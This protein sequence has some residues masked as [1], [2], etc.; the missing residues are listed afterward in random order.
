MTSDRTRG[1]LVFQTPDGRWALRVGP[2]A[3]VVGA[4]L[5][6]GGVMSPLA[7]LG[8]ATFVVG[9]AAIAVG[10]RRRRRLFRCYRCGVEYERRFVLYE[11]MESI[12]ARVDDFTSG[13]L[14][15][16][17]WVIGKALARKHRRLG[18]VYTDYHL[19]F[20]GHAADG[21]FLIR[22]DSG[23]F[24]RRREGVEYLIEAAT[25]AIARRM[26]ARLD[27]TGEVAWLRDLVLCSD[28]L[29]FGQTGR[30]IPYADLKATL[31]N[32]G[33]TLELRGPD[34]FGTTIAASE[35]NFYPGYSLLIENLGAR[36]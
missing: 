18:S 30:R 11:E 33:Q 14:A 16:T 36:P 17:Q 9:L 23:D 12:Q 35:R 21:H 8:V 31:D 4:C 26:R 3:V 13:E 7:P 10:L 34:G 25:A 32:A 19:V 20:E 27:R 15:V 6:V 29:L 1:P 24:G 5:V 2:C 28:S 22:F